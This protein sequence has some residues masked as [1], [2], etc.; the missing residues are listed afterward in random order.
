[1]ATEDQLEDLIEQTGDEIMFKR[2]SGQMW[3]KPA[4][5]DDSCFGWGARARSDA[6]VK[7]LSED[8]FFAWDPA[9]P[10]QLVVATAGSA[11][12]TAIWND[13]KTI[14][15]LAIK[16]GE[17]RTS[18]AK[19]KGFEWI[20]CIVSFFFHFFFSRHLFLLTSLLLQRFFAVVIGT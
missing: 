11:G 1:L 12:G 10:V 5:L 9:H 19:Q 18:V 7:A 13:A 14:P 17:H 15:K 4:M 3:V 20:T 2:E 6:A 16:D 8:G